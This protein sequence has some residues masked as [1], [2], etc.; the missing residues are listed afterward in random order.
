M[1][2]G[3]KNISSFRQVPTLRYY[4]RASW[5]KY[6]LFPFSIYFSFSTFP[7][8]DVWFFFLFF[9]R[10]YFLR[11][12]ILLIFFISRNFVY[13]TL[14]IVMWWM[15]NIADS[16]GNLMLLVNWH[17]NF[18]TQEESGL[19]LCLSCSVSWSGLVSQWFIV[20][21]FLIIERMIMGSKLDNFESVWIICTGNEAYSLYL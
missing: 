7:S 16:Y 2:R 12:K 9:L 17:R 6:N 21:Q 10:R 13:L 14:N 15:G 1:R 3:K 18:Y 11:W 5:F 4:R 8:F 20:L 19:V